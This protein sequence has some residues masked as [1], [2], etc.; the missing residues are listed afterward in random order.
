M[1][2]KQRQGPIMFESLLEGPEQTLEG[3]FSM[4]G[5]GGLF[6]CLRAWEKALLPHL[7]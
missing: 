3:K 2:G 6:D 1:V 4:F 7:L 5:T